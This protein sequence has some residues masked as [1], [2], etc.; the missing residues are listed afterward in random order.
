MYI[1]IHM[2]LC[3]VICHSCV[4]ASG[5][6]MQWHEDF[7]LD[8]SWSLRPKKANNHMCQGLNSHGFSMVMVI[9]PI[10]GFYKPIIRTQHI[11][12]WVVWSGWLWPG[13]FTGHILGWIVY[14]YIVVPRNL[15]YSYSWFVWYFNYFESLVTFL[16]NHLSQHLH[17][18]FVFTIAM[19]TCP[20]VGSAAELTLVL[21]IHLM[22]G[23]WKA[24]MW[25][26]LIDCHQSNM[27]NKLDTF[28][29]FQLCHISCPNEIS[30]IK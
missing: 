7:L 24:D 30:L 1:Y 27:L 21:F 17:P 3:N 19:A 29:L 2:Q 14:D 11:W 13:V 8:P 25:L 5:M 15:L 16:M 28:Y 9:N 4:D 20:A 10:V 22:V 18:T 23:G 12:V 26:K 6:E